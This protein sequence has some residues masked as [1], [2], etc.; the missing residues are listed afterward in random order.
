MSLHLLA[1]W[2]QDNMSAYLHVCKCIWHN[3]INTCMLTF[4][5]R[6]SIASTANAGKVKALT[7]LSSN[8]AHNQT[9]RLKH[10]ER[11]GATSLQKKYYGSIII[12]MYI[13]VW[14]AHLISWIGR[15]SSAE[16]VALLSLSVA[17]STSPSL[18][19]DL[20][21]EYKS[22]PCL[23]S[24]MLIL[25]QTDVDQ[26]WHGA[27]V[28]HE[29]CLCSPLSPGWDSLF[30]LQLNCHGTGGGWGRGQGASSATAGSANTTTAGAGGGSGAGGR[31]KS[32]WTT[33]RFTLGFGG[34]RFGCM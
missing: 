4:I 15:R 14:H 31:R 21:G 13:V 10:I 23:F 17:S 20:H 29:G 32:C 26:I 7:T 33:C 27:P 34:G 2:L 24:T 22:Q 28:Q 12:G 30:G 19:W 18:W 3:I 6:R 16:G 8:G 9:I 25:V 5:Q 11:R 1:V